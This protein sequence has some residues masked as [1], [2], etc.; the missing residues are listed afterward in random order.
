[1]PYEPIR[2][3]EGETPLTWA[4]KDALW[5]EIVMGTPVAESAVPDTE[6]SRRLRRRLGEE[7]QDMR[8]R[9]ITGEHVKD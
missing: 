8:R 2:P 1:M 9:G 4:E 6:E 3:A 7:W 5:T